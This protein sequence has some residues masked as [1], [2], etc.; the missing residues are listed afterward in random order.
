MFNQI[1]SE[2]YYL[3]EDEVIE[4]RVNLIEHSKF[5]NS[6]TSQ[7]DNYLVLEHLIQDN[8]LAHS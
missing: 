3:T 5:M 1:Y 4:F 6:I 7:Q 8:C 2:F